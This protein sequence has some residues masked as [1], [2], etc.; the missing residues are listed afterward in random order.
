MTNEQYYNY[1]K[2]LLE[3]SKG[4]SLITDMRKLLYIIVYVVKKHMKLKSACIFHYDEA[5]KVFVL[6]GKRGA[7]NIQGKYRIN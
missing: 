3:A 6:K 1:H 2:T 5:S 4:M 7:V